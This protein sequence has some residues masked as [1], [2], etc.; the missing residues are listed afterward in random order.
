MPSR[1]FHKGR[2]FTLSFAHLSHDLFPAFLA[3]MLP[4]LIEKLGLSFLFASLL[5]VVRRIPFLLNPFLGLLA[6]RAGARYFV[7][8][9]P[10]ITAIS[11][12]FVG[13]A[14]SAWML[15]VLLFIAGLSATLFHIPSPVMIKESAGDKVGLGMSLFM[16]GGEAARTLG[17]L[18]ITAAISWWGIEG[19]YRLMPL[20]IVASVILYSKLHTLRPQLS[21]QKPRQKGDTKALLVRYFPFFSAIGGFILFQAWM[22]TALVLFLPVY[23]GEKGYGLWYA[24]ISLALLEFF[25]ILGALTAGHYS[26]KIGRPKILLIISIAQ[27]GLMTGFLLSSQ[28]FMLPFLGLLGFFLFASGP[29]IM[30]SVQDTNTSMPTFMN[31]LYMGVNFGLTSAVVVC[32]G[33]LGDALGLAQTYWICALM[34]YGCIGVALVLPRAIAAGKAA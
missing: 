1:I 9:T 2:V 25:G 28:T 13:L 32:V 29:V 4:L 30:A 5:D 12:S 15:L 33:T 34:G 31:S 10:A 17:P 19:A 6:E 14:S 22:K 23:L 3:P 20:G 21:L 8:F 11:M 24:G 27:A 18:L 7:I 16:V 26:D